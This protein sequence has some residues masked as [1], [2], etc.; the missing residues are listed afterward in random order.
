VAVVLDHTARSGIRIGAASGVGTVCIGAGTPQATDT[1]GTATAIGYSA[2][3]GGNSTFNG[4]AI[5]YQAGSNVN[6]AFNGVAI[7]YQAGS[8]VSAASNGVAIGSL[9][10]SGDHA[11]NYGVAIGVLAG[12]SSSAAS[13]GVAIGYYAGFGGSAAY[14]GVA[15]GYRAGYGA[16]AASNGVAIGCF[17]GFSGSAAYNGVAI[18]YYAGYSG[19]VGSNTMVGYQSGYTPSGTNA[20]TTATGQTLIG[21]N[22]GQASAIQVNYITCLGHQATAGASGAVAIGVDHNGTSAT[23]S[24]QD[25]IKLGTAAHTVSLSAL[26]YNSMATKT[27]AYTALLTDSVVL[28]NPSGGAFTVTLP[29]ATLGQQVIVKNIDNT[30]GNQVTVVPA[31]GTIDGGSSVALASYTSNTFVS[32][33]TNWWMV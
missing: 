11:A 18:G 17:A 13:N 19:T 15:I 29:A 32:D 1:S 25:E 4:V 20:T 24:V 3:Y 27:A 16:V 7:G 14:N 28:A 33:G 22:T 26:R 2:G 12:A 5:G 30:T 23:T 10:G 31:T 6:G 8:N 9:A 21:Y